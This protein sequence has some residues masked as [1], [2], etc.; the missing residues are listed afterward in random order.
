VWHKSRV[1]M[2]LSAVQVVQLPK[3]NI[4]KVSRY[5]PSLARHAYRNTVSI[6]VKTIPAS[7]RTMSTEATQEQR[8][9]PD[10][11]DRVCHCVDVEEYN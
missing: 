3:L 4:F 8:I 11:V 1:D 10:V 2:R 9:N 6:A 7:I 5:L